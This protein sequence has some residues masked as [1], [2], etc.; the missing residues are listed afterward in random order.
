MRVI[1]YRAYGN[2][3][4]YAAIDET[5]RTARFVR[6]KCVRLWMD[7]KDLEKGVSRYDLSRYTT[8]LRKEYEWC[9]KLNST[10]VQV[11]GERAWSA[12]S[13][14]YRNLR[15]SVKPVG[16]PRFKN[17]HGGRSVEYKRSG[18]KLDGANKRMTFTDGFG[19]GTL[20]LKGTWDIDLHPCEL[21]RRVRLVRKADGYHVQLTVDSERRE[22]IVPPTGKAVG[23]DMGL[24]S[25]Y[26]D[27][28][29]KKVENP[30]Y[31]R[32]SE[33]QLRRIQRRVS[34]KFRRGCKQSN[35]YRK[36]RKKLARKHL[37]VGR[38]RRDHAVKAARCVVRSNDLIAYE[39]LRVRNM[40]K[41]YSLAKSI[42]DAGWCS[43][44][45]WLEYYGQIYGKVTVA[46]P[47]EYTSQDCSRCGGRVKKSLST[48]THLCQCGAELDRDHNA[49]LNI[50]ERGLRTVGHTGTRA[51]DTVARNAC[52]EDV[53][54][55]VLEADLVEARIPRFSGGEC[56][57]AVT[58]GVWRG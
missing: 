19:I 37:K 24:E 6:N 26:T 16:Y 50:L 39:D 8:N 21:I 18:W 44:R 12:I 15:E 34:R 41:N 43:F 56:Q 35:N 33:K 20:K 30:R 49:A 29:G 22:D 23:I 7:S 48:R 38:Q 51:T 40:V 47:P 57:S 1:E 2:P 55:R 46:V 10:A 53:R 52:G 11:A 17:E 14:F 25:F 4:Q 28:E 32:K 31:L 45:R 42:N 27:S 58:C 9:G 13:C 3:R 54:P 36:A 5:I